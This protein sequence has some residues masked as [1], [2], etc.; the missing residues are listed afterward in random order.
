MSQEHLK[1]SKIRDGTVIDHITPG[2]ALNVLSLLN[3]DGSG[4][5]TVSVVMN[6]PSNRQDT[7]DI[8][9]IEGRE[10][11]E[12]EI[13][14][15]SV[16]A[17]EAT[18]NIVRGYEVVEKH[19]VT[20]PDKIVNAISCPNPNCITASEREPAETSFTVIDDG[21][22]CDYCDEIIRDG[23]TAHLDP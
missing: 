19:R 16:V 3:I 20:R 14:V 5:E 13:D 18:I 8:V 23:I 22:R 2:Q 15:L 11:D 21:V 1:V 4:G 12:D 7:K 10:L 9:K 6:A 17:P